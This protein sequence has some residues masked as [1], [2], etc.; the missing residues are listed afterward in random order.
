MEQRREIKRGK[1]GRPSSSGRQEQGER[2][3]DRARKETEAGA[4]AKTVEG[5]ECKA[6]VTIREKTTRQGTA[7][8]DDT[9]SIFDM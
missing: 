5:G 1:L 3:G 7:G 8:Q 4:A 9:C 6:G 2:R